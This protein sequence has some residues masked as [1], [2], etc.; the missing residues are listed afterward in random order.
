MSVDCFEWKSCDWHLPE[1]MS[2]SYKYKNKQLEFSIGFSV[3]CKYEKIAELFLCSSE[4][5][6]WDLHL[7]E[8]KEYPMN[9]QRILELS[10]KINGVAFEVLYRVITSQK[11]NMYKIS[12]ESVQTCED[13]PGNK[14]STLITVE[15]SPE[16]CQCAWDFALCRTQSRMLY[17]DLLD[18]SCILPQSL[19]CLIAEAEDTTPPLPQRVFNPILYS[20]E[21]KFLRSTM[22]YI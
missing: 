3:K 16:Y 22:Q 7:S 9:G 15:A 11:G 18:E 10:F 5:K 6:K 4:R 19:S 14:S 8:M 2:V 13:L 1:G 20:C 12:L 21:R 17:P